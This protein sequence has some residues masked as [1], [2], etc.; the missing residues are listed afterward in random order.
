MVQPGIGLDTPQTVA[1]DTTHLNHH[2]LDFDISQEQS[3]QSPA[4][5][6]N[7]LIDQ[8]RNARRG[9]GSGSI[10]TPRSRAVLIDRRNLPDAIGGGE[11]TPMLKSATRNSGL[12]GK[13]NSTPALAKL[14]ALQN[15]PEDFSP[16][17]EF[18][19]SAYGRSRNGSYISGT[20]APQLE[21]SS[22]ASTPMALLP[23]RNEG[24]GALQ[25]GNQLSLRE[26]E[27]VIDRV[28][29]ENFGLKLKIHFLEDAL[30]KAGPG[31]SEAAL[32]ENT[33]LKVDKKCRRNPRGS[34]LT[35]GSW[36]K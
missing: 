32:K 36:T 4:K 25:D 33:E 20:P 11:F 30:R 2:A 18:G 35:R 1:G 26:Q 3:F 6:K 21:S 29:K 31:F 16:L 23:R 8:L 19:S 14:R 15:I 22:N 27:N 24:R 13:E 5:D 34:S 28:E 10:K 7:N 9:N 17:P 12:R